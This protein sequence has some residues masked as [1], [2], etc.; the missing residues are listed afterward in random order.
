MR[1]D[2]LELGQILS[3]VV[4]HFLTLGGIGQ[5]HMLLDHGFQF[6]HIIFG[7]DLTGRY[8]FLIQ[9][10]VQI[11]AFIQYISDT[12]AHTG[13]EIFTGHTEN[14]HTTAGHVFTAMISYTLDN[15]DGTGVTHAET[16]ACHTVDKCLTGGC[17]VQC[18]VTDDDVFLRLELATLGRIYHQLTTG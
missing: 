11:V 16:L 13:C 15:C 14:Y 4:Q 8:H 12:A 2:L 17:T 18:H 6:Q 5:C 1:D 7:C 10:L 9:T 3:K